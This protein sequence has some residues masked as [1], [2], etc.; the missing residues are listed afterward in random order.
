MTFDFLT[1]AIA[2]NSQN[3]LKE[4]CKTFTLVNFC[5]KILFP[6]F[7]NARYKTDRNFLSASS[8]RIPLNF[9]ISVFI[10][11]VSSSSYLLCSW[12]FLSNLKRLWASV[13][14][15]GGFSKFGGNGC[16]LSDGL[17]RFSISMFSLA[18]IAN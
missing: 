4:I 2:K 12:I 10:E 6:S 7:P 14:P 9:L 11:A 5:P 17:S 15:S 18:I 3:C 8:I 16:C 1:K 13:S